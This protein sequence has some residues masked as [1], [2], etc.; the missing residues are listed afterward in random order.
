[1]ARYTIT[2]TIETPDHVDAGTILD[3]AT[4]AV[5][6]VLTNLDCYELHAEHVEDG[7][8]PSVT[9]WK[10]PTRGAG[11]Q[12][13]KLEKAIRDASAI[14]VAAHHDVKIEAARKLLNGVKS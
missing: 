10:P 1:M 12:R 8:S 13:A 2:F 3:A 9:E 7:S 6:D 4:E 5:P 11:I 14:L